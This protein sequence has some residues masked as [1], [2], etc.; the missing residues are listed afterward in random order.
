MV[1]NVVP[2]DVK[3]V[4]QL[5]MGVVIDEFKRFGIV[6]YAAKNIADRAKRSG[7]FYVDSSLL[8]KGMQLAT[9]VCFLNCFGHTHALGNCQ[10]TIYTA[11]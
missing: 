4:F 10:P 7:L 2:T 1:S 8:S 11:L 6:Q 5:E 9:K 3:H